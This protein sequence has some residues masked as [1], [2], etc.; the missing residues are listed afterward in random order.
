M[1]NI[2]RWNLLNGF[3]NEVPVWALA[4]FDF[5]KFE[6]QNF[7]TWM[8]HI[9]YDCAL[10]KINN[11]QPI[12]NQTLFFVQL[13]YATVC[14]RYRVTKQTT[15]WNGRLRKCLHGIAWMEQNTYAEK[16]SNR[17]SS[18]FWNSILVQFTHFFIFFFS[19]FNTG[20]W[21]VLSSFTSKLI[22]GATSGLWT[23]S[24]QIFCCRI[25]AVCF[26]ARLT[27]K[28]TGTFIL[29]LSLCIFH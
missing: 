13:N 19:I 18:L 28:C 20:L 6:M 12:E 21:S 15:F 24:S 8:V 29:H 2:N 25:S 11:N 7:F 3:E 10:W 4:S 5:A 23:L 1:P 9:S 16:H 26:F 14:Y 27:S 17:Y 22:V